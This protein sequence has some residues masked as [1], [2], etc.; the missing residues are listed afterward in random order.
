[1]PEQAGYEV[2]SYPCGLEAWT[3]EIPP[4][5][6]VKKAQLLAGGEVVVDFQD[7][8]LHLVSYSQPIEKEMT[9]PELEPHLH[10][11]KERPDAIP[12]KYSYYKK[13]WG[14]CL[15]KTLYDELLMDN[16]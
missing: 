13:D 7:H 14:F 2:K 8:P 12:W 11:S 3:W 5:Y 10:Y 1:M 16:A 4:R 9:W 6:E 15:S